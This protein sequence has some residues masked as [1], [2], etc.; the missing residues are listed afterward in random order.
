MKNLMHH[1]IRGCGE[2][3]TFGQHPGTGIVLILLIAMTAAAG[4]HGLL[5]GCIFY[6][7]M[8]FWGAYHRSMEDPPE[9]NS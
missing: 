4:W 6:L 1:I 7:P 3:P 2:L 8:Y 9:D 5:I